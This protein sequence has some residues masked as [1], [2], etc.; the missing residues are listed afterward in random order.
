M[1]ARLPRHLKSMI[2]YVSFFNCKGGCTMNDFKSTK[3]FGS[4]SF[5]DW[6]WRGPSKPLFSIRVEAFVCIVC[7]LMASQ[8]QA[9]LL[10]NGSFEADAVGLGLTTITGWSVLAGNVDVDDATVISFAAED[11]NKFLETVG[12]PG[13]ATI[14]QSFPTTPGQQYE[15]TGWLAHHPGIG[16][17]TALCTVSIDSNVIGLLVHGGQWNDWRPFDLTFNATSATTQLKIQDITNRYA[18]G[19]MLIDNLKVAPIPEPS[20]VVLAAVGLASL[21]AWRRQHR[22]QGAKK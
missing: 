18:F 9:N 22:R 3:Q 6:Y 14:T 21:A 16:T 10:V 1:T 19:G 5:L 4:S 13:A 8:A 7:L 15:F 11:G 20:T 12:T 2:R 17:A